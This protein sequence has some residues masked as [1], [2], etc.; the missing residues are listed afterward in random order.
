MWTAESIREYEEFMAL[1]RVWMHRQLDAEK[2]RDYRQA[3]VCY[4]K[5]WDCMNAALVA[6][7]PDPELD[8]AHVK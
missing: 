5:R 7:K 1:E 2:A 3:D 4:A 8:P 6:L